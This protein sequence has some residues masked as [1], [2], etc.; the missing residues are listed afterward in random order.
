M[1]S[2]WAK[3]QK[4]ILSASAALLLVM[5]IP[6]S[7][8]PPGSNFDLTH[9]KLTLPLD[10]TGGTTGVATE[11]SAAQL[12]A[13]Y[14]NFY[15]YSA[16]DGAMIFWCPVIGATTSGTTF[17]RSE[18]RELVNP[19]NASINWT[20][21]GTHVLRAQCQVTQQPS[22]GAIIIGQIHGYSY[23]QRLVKLQFNAGKVEAYVR[24]SP[25]LSGDTKF[26]YASVPL[27]GTINYEIKVVDGV[28][29]I[30]VN[31]VTNSHNFFASDPAWR[32]NDFYF[33]AGSYVQDNSGVATEGGRVAFYQLS[34]SHGT[35][36]PPATTA[37]A[38]Q[39]ISRTVA[40][41]A[42]VIVSVSALGS[43]PLAYQWRT[44]A[45]VF[46]GHTNAS[47]SITNF[48]AGDQ[49]RYDVIVSGP[50]GAVTS[51]VATLYLNAPLRFTN[52]N[53]NAARRFNALLLGVA[54]SNYVV[55]SSSNLTTWISLATNSS[56]SGIIDFTDPNP[57]SGARYYRAK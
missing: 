10:A 55:Q 25:T 37:I 35:T 52:Q 15:F 18:L 36:Q 4:A 44:N 5:S 8:L 14:T 26:T 11:I 28:A 27:N 17:P 40:P 6:L 42:N 20:G 23:S 13:G 29:S 49:K 54:N 45:V 19:N 32:T 3:R 31:G 21:D 33:K 30:A 39:P 34:V 47:L 57:V 1:F 2:I 38:T 53:L 24:N 12:V 56:P 22:A 43:A 48:H 9:W 16:P 46:P 7:A 41:G 51:A 50:G